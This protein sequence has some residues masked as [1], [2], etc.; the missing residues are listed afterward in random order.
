VPRSGLLAFA[1]AQPERAAVLGAIVVGVLVRAWF[2]LSSDFPLNDGALFLVMA[3]T[4]EAAHFRLPATVLYNG[5]VIPFGYSPLGF[6]L[7]AALHRV[8][9]LDMTQGLRVLPLLAT[10]GCLVAFAAFARDVLPRVAAGVTRP[11]RAAAGAVLA[12][13]LLPRSYVWLLMGGGLTRSLGFLFAI[14]ATHQAFLLYTRGRWSHAGLMG[15][16]AGLTALSHLGTAPFAAFSM[17]LMFA[18]FARTRVAVLGSVAA[19]AIAVLLAAPW[20][21]S[22]VGHHGWAPFAAARATGGN[23]LTDSDTRWGIRMHFAVF[24]IDTVGEPLFPIISMLGFLGVL[25][26]LRARQWVLPAWVGLILLIDARAPGTYEAVPV[27]LLAGIGI[28]AVLLPLLFPT[29]RNDGPLRAEPHAGGAGFGGLSPRRVGWAPWL[30]LGALVAYAGGMAVTRSESVGGE[31]KLLRGLPRDERAA[32][33]WV[34]RN[35][36]ADARFLVVTGPGHTGVWGDRVSEWFPVLAQRVSLATMQGRE[37]INDGRFKAHEA[38]YDRLQGCVSGTGACL[39][40]WAERTGTPYTDVFITKE[41]QFKVTDS[42]KAALRRDTGFVVLY[43]GA[44]ALVAARRG[45]AGRPV[46]GQGSGG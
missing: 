26:S 28:S 9:G 32:M 25:A 34:A 1:V 10:S 35:S 6:Y 2:V 22:V 16:F 12:F 29:L 4:V 17:A 46:S 7:L 38:A 3:R 31:A 19:F 30:I 20:V 14:L 24:G 5:T 21:G 39:D 45:A 13:A 41:P 15:L 36:P 42:L 18:A 33:A 23:V 8:F 11:G 40:K 43:D 37:W 44:G 27:S